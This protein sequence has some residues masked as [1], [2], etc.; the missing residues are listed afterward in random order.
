M[1]HLQKKLITENKYGCTV[2]T[3]V[4]SKTYFIKGKLSCNSRNVL[5]LITCSNCREHYV[6]SA[7]DFKQKETI[8]KSHIKTN[9]DRCGVS[10]HFNK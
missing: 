4:T 5:Y 1:R 7:I 9:K 2:T 3:M 8:P 10:S 6:G